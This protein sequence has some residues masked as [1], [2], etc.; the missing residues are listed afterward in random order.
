MVAVVAHG[1]A[2]DDL[3]AP[4]AGTDVLQPTVARECSSASPK[5]PTTGRGV[6]RQVAPI[7]ADRRR[8]T[9]ARPPPCGPRPARRRRTA[10]CRSLAELQG[11]VGDRSAGRRREVPGQH[12]QVRL[13]RRH[14]GAASGSA[15]SGV[16]SLG[17]RPLRP[18][19]P[20]PHSH[21]LRRQRH[22]AVRWPGSPGL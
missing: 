16:C 9:P 7:R 18:H 20:E 8:G 4:A 22:D 5:I 2:F 14:R 13:L 21:H 11:Q 1:Q 15:S 3:E 12:P 10:S 6:C 17:V 19:L